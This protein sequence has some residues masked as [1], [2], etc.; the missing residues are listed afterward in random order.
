MKSIAGGIPNAQFAVIP[1]AG[2]MSPLE[3]PA[4]F[5]EALREFLERVTG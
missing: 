5:N 3:N 4:A 2:H 1:D